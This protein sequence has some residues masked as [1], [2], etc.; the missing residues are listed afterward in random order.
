[1][2]GEP[3]PPLA[4]YPPPE[5]AWFNSRPSYS[6]GKNNGFSYTLLIR[7]YH[8]WGGLQPLTSRSPAAK[9][10]RLRWYLRKSVESAVGEFFIATHQVPV[11]VVS[12]KVERDGTDLLWM[13]TSVADR[14]LFNLVY[15]YMIYYM[16]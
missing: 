13:S 16:F 1:M 6:K 2:A 14:C 7:P 4:T 12:L 3:T 15:M 5:I 8:F 10:V 9:S 11:G